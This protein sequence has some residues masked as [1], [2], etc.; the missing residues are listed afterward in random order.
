MPEGLSTLLLAVAGFVSGVVNVVAGG[1]SFLT[2]PVLIF[3]GLPAGEANAT[4]RVAILTQNLGAVVSFQRHRV[5]EW[6]RA[7]DMV[8]PALLGSAA[9][10]W[11]ALQVADRDFRRIL[12]FLMVAVTL[13]T[14]WWDAQRRRAGA[15]AAPPRP[16][17][18]EDK[19]P[20]RLGA[21]GVRAA[22]V[23]VGLYGGFVQAGVGFLVLAV[24]TLAGFDLVRG[25][26]LKVLSVLAL[27][28]LSLALFA[29]AGRVRWAPGLVLGAGSLA[30]SVVG[31]RLT[32]ARGHA[33]IQG[34]VVATVIVFALMLWV[35]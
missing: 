26:A 27:T 32:V 13:W 19:P 30:G 22:F 4:N 24:T 29:A 6:R 7:A 8:V 33:W 2:L 34:V 28:V 17:A 5:L 15:D 16:S 1:G 10:T 21:W 18:A 9:G 14:L 35:S 3:L 12:S 25:N 20:P 31:A 23:V 11:A